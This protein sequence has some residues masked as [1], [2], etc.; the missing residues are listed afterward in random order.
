MSN[1]QA[2][3]RGASTGYALIALVCLVNSFCNS[4]G[5]GSTS[6]TQNDT[7][8]PN[9][10]PSPYPTATSVDIPTASSTP[11]NSPGGSNGGPVANNATPL[12][13]PSLTPTPTQSP[14]VTPTPTQTP[15]VTVAA[16]SPTI[17]PTAFQLTADQVIQK[18]IDA[19]P[20]TGGIVDESSLS[21]PQLLKGVVS[22]SKPTRL[23]LNGMFSYIGP[24]VTSG[25]FR[26]LPGSDGSS[27]QCSTLPP[28]LATSPSPCYISAAVTGI[29]SL[30]A[31]GS[32]PSDYINNISIQNLTFL[33]TPGVSAI[34]QANEES[35]DDIHVVGNTVVTQG[36][37]GGSTTFVLFTGGSG[38][39][40]DNNLVISDNH[41]SGVAVGVDLN[42]SQVVGTTIEHNVFANLATGPCLKLENSTAYNVMI[43]ENLFVGTSL[44]PGGATVYIDGGVATIVG[45]VWQNNK[46]AALTTNG[47]SADLEIQGGALIN[48]YGNQFLGGVSNIDLDPSFAINITDV[49]SKAIIVGNQ[50]A[51]Y[52]QGGVRGLTPGSLYLG[53]SFSQ[54]N[55]P[56]STVYVGP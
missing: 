7:A 32:G 34:I 41:V 16:E 19:L 12:P 2:K 42:T 46:T 13:R 3:G 56:G 38:P 25:L 50:I 55:S 21:G 33:A 35:G 47:N 11:N 52:A 1:S 39:G 5:G 28:S 23:I 22:I 14:A 54:G 10:S 4:C 30:I 24:P 44:Q 45:N 43:G 53:N 31:I 29:G 6:G 17:S 8:R 20:P 36:N 48:A 9:I 15:T 18:A 26:F 27:I 37:G 40:E 49:Q 51:N